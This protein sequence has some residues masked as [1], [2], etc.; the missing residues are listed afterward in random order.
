MTTS[1]EITSLHGVFVCT[2]TPGEPCDVVEIPASATHEAVTLRISH[3]PQNAFKLLGYMRYLIN[4]EAVLTGKVDTGT[5][6]E[7]DVE[8]RYRE[9]PVKALNC[10][11]TL[12]PDFYHFEV[13]EDEIVKAVNKG[14]R[15]LKTTFGYMATNLPIQ[16]SQHPDTTIGTTAFGDSANL[17]AAHPHWVFSHLTG[18]FLR[19]TQ[20]APPGANAPFTGV[21]DL[22]EILAHGSSIDDYFDNLMERG[23]WD[24]AVKYHTYGAQ[25]SGNLVLPIKDHVNACYLDSL[26]ANGLLEGPRELAIATAAFNLGVTS[27]DA[28]LL[29]ISKRYFF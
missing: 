28:V 8:Y 20:K 24:A 3:H 5:L 27:K 25:S 18:H 13:N 14:Y 10:D 21:D 22:Q 7:P 12:T 2:Y 4:T 15:V 17:V 29:A 1:M 16:N 26:E 9:T 19:R 23:T 6:R 11:S